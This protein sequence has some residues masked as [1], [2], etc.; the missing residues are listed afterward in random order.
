MGGRRVGEGEMVGDY[1]HNWVVGLEG[2]VRFYL[3]DS[4]FYHLL[5]SS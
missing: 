3:F 4:Y 1:F 2:V 5:L